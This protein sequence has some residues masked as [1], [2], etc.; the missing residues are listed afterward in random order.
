MG[1]AVP[2]QR[3]ARDGAEPSGRGDTDTLAQS[4]RLSWEW[5]RRGLLSFSPA[6]TCLCSK[7]GSWFYWR[8]MGG[9]ADAGSSPVPCSIP[10]SQGCT[11]KPWGL[12]LVLNLKINQL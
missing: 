11:S 10:G 4:H 6:Q 5:R 2:M 9:T 7:R 1:G 3:G 12:L 8:V